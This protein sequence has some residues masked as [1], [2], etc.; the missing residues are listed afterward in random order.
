[1]ERGN[2][3]ERQYLRKISIKLCKIKIV[4][5]KH[6]GSP[7]DNSLAH[8]SVS[9]HFKRKYR[10]VPHPITSFLHSPRPQGI[11]CSFTSG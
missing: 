8:S 7:F 1:M 4:G 9:T 3:T 10:V 5:D 11:V 2:T 6:H